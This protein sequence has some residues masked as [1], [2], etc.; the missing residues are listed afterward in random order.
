MD[1]SET[2]IKMCQMAVKAHPETFYRDSFDSHDYTFKVDGNDLLWPLF[3]QDQLQEM[4]PNAFAT[5]NPQYKLIS[6][7]NHFY[8]YWDAHGIPDTLCSREQLELAFVMH[9]RY[10]KE[11]DGSAWVVSG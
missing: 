2:Y 9:E 3:R 5:S 11:W 7:L 1:T 4:V 6:E 8:G 10:Q